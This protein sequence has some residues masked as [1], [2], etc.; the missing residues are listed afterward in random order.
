MSL[1]TDRDQAEKPAVL[2]LSRVPVLARESATGVADQERKHRAAVV[3]VLLLSDIVAAVGTCLLIDYAFGH[4]STRAALFMVPLLAASLWVAGLHSD[5]GLCPAERLRRRVISI[6]AFTA[7]FMVMDTSNWGAGVL[8]AAASQAVLLILVSFYF[9]VWAQHLLVRRGL[10]AARSATF[11]NG[12][13][14]ARRRHNPLMK[15]AFDLIVVVPAALLAAPL[16]AVMAIGIRIT[17]KGPAFYT[18]ER[19]GRGERMFR[20]FKLRSMFVHAE[21]RL[22]QYLRCNPAA[23][24]EWDRFCKLSHD[25]RALPYIGNLLRRTSL[26]ELPQLW[27]II[28]GDM[29]LIGPR[30]FPP[31]HTE[32]FDRPFQRTRASVQPGLTG[33][34]QVC[35]RSESDLTVQKSLDLY[36]IENWSIWLDLYILLQTPPAVFLRHGAK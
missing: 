20:L 29:T 12:A 28:C 11:G 5:S 22:E 3:S 30:P 13:P 2:R 7:A 4:A 24:A 25:P 23:R 6:A 21:Q 27:N 36:Y 8:P 14:T 33:L 1:A 10:L 9:D 35:G 32:K 19:V 16:I 17:S 26:D 15:R 18:Q 31:Y 34:W